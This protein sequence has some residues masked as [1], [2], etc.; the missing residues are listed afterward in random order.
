MKKEI[1]N[2]NENYIIDWV[3]VSNDPYLHEGERLKRLQNNVTI[4]QMQTC[5]C[6]RC[7]DTGVTNFMFIDEQWE[8]RLAYALCTC[9]AI[10]NVVH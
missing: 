8:T 7:F 10:K 5:K 1:Q 3:T 6:T 9:D 2:Y 4:E